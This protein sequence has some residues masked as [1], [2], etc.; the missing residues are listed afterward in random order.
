MEPSSQHNA[1]CPPLLLGYLRPHWADMQIQSLSLG[2]KAAV[3]GLQPEVMEG[4]TPLNRHPVLP[5]H[6]LA[7]PHVLAADSELGTGPPKSSGKQPH[8][9]RLLPDAETP[10]GLG[11]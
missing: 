10:A 7:H 4:L 3:P 9:P 8:Y 1:L 6:L 11:V 5:L 2:F